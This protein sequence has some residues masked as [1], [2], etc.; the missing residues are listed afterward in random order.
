MKSLRHS[1]TRRVLPSPGSPSMRATPPWPASTVRSEPCRSDSSTPRPVSG[2]F[3]A[4]ALRPGSP[5][6]RA[7]GLSRYVPATG[8]VPKPVVTSS[9]GPRWKIPSVAFRVAGPTRTEAGLATDCNAAA[10]PTTP[11]IAP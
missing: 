6:T 10:T 4:T 5:V 7:L 2:A 8:F 1:E 3:R 9:L 11:P